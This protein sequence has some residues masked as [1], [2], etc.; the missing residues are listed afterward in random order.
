[1][2][3]DEW[4]RALDAD[5]WDQALR[6]RIER[7]QWSLTQTLALRGETV[8]LEWGTWSR[9]ERDVIRDWCRANGVAVEL[10]YLEVPLDELWAR[11][12]LR[13]Q[14]PGETVIPRAE[15]ESW[16]GGPFEAPTREEL[17]LYD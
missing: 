3:P 6:A 5:L 9:D 1:M 2:S 4:M 12:E 17:A 8:V 14:Q 15:L 10:R 16:L 7:L 13:N 11:L